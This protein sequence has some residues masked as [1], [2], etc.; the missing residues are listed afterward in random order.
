MQNSTSPTDDDNDDDG[1]NKQ[2]VE[3]VHRTTW[4]ETIQRRQKTFFHPIIGALLD[5]ERERERAGKENRLY[6][7]KRWQMKW[8][9]IRDSDFLF[10]TSIKW[11]NSTFSFDAKIFLVSSSF[12]WWHFFL[13]I[14]EKW[15]FQFKSQKHFHSLMFSTLFLSISLLPPSHPSFSTSVIASRS[16]LHLHLVWNGRTVLFFHCF[17]VSSDKSLCSKFKRRQRWW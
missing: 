9:L 11:I 8:Y 13:N 10:S 1:D 16:K 7:F 14:L 3:R 17:S 15:I 5:G 4:T 2:R 12:I 6:Y